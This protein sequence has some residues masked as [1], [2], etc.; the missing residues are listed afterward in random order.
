MSKKEGEKIYG[1]LAT[2]CFSVKNESAH[3]HVDI[4]GPQLDLAD[5]Q[6]RNEFH[7]LKNQPIILLTPKIMAGC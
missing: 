6:V 1:H 5:A 2:F 3:Y 7:D 4:L